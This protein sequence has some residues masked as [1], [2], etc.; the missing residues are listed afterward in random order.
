MSKEN[1]EVT[2]IDS[3]ERVAL[4]LMQYIQSQPTGIK[5]RTTGTEK[6]H[7]EMYRKC[8]LVVSGCDPV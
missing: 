3:K 5:I 4:E 2:T 8:L 6:E 1:R 7:L